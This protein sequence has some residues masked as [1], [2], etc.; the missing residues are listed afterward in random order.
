MPPRRA[1]PRAYLLRTATNM[2]IDTLRRRG[3]EGTALAE[4]P[5]ETGAG[6]EAAG[7]VRDVGTLLLQRLAP[8]ERAAVVL[9]ELFDYSLDEI[10]DW[11]ACWPS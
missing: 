3:S 11:R 6:A 5:V 8:Q 4:Q 10:A 9:K 2:W 1:N 7:A